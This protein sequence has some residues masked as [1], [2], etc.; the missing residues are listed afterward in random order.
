MKILIMPLCSLL[1]T[2]TNL[3]LFDL[4]ILLVTL[5]WRTL[6]HWTIQCA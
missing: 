4:K 6:Y 5:F 3:P 1:Q 2:A